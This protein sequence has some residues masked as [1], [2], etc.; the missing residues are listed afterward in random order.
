MLISWHCFSIHCLT[1]VDS[2]W[3]SRKS[4]THHRKLDASHD[5]ECWTSHWV[6]SRSCEDRCLSAKSN[7]HE[8]LD[9]RS[10]HDLEEDIHRDQA[11]NWSCTSMRMQMLLIRWSQVIVN[12]RQTRQIHEQRQT[13]RLHE[14]CEKY[15]QAI[16]SLNFRSW[17]SHQE[18][19]CQV[20]WRWKEWRHELATLQADIQRSFRA[21]IC[22]KII[23][24]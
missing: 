20:R 15:Q 7:H 12:R 4:H 21:K 2:K 17:S 5:Q 16:S 24:E 18:S 1:H 13:W 19:C 10:S 3:S 14:I 22:E 6:L 23:K 8:T 9:R 11:L